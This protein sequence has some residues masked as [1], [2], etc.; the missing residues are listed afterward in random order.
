MTIVIIMK[1]MSIIR[2][3]SCNLFTDNNK[4]V[5]E[6]RFLAYNIKKEKT[7]EFRTF[8]SLELL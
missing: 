8:H 7:L 5:G 2:Q 3:K 1:D 6:Y 4:T